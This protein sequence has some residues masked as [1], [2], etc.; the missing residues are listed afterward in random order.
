MYM[1]HIVCIFDTC[2]NLIEKQEEMESVE[3]ALVGT[4]VE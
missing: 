3:R 1:F 4:E 2:G